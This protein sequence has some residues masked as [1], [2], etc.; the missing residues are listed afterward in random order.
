MEKEK[1]QNRNPMIQEKRNI[2]EIGI[3]YGFFFLFVTI[4]QIG[5]AVIASFRK[6]LITEEYRLI[7][8]YLILI[9]STYVIG[10]PFLRYLL[11]KIPN[12][13]I[14]QAD[15]GISGFIKGLFCMFGILFIGLVLGQVSNS[16]INSFLNI[17]AGSSN[18]LEMIDKTNPIYTAVTVGILGPVFEELIFRKKLID[19]TIKYGKGVAILASGIMF[20]LF[21][22]SITQFFSATGMGM[23]W[24]YI[25]IKTGRIRYS[26]MYHM[27]N[28]LTV[29]VFL[30]EMVKHLDVLEHGD[31]S[32]QTVICFALLIILCFIFIGIFCVI[33]NIKNFFRIMKRYDFKGAFHILM[34]SRG[35]WFYYVLCFLMLI[36]RYL[37]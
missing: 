24:A 31:L 5:I 33:K 37:K 11:R 26:I 6:D 28:N 20:G 1:M 17:S 18:T 29:S 22:T 10:Y 36:E 13:R 7:F 2:S 35:M 4:L 32:I 23:L 15:L 14:E 16:L 3:K 19:C 30:V 9:I 8:A 27:I 34:T 21:H 12:E 25:Y